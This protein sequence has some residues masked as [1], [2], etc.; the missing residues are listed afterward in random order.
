M[1]LSLFP[2]YLLHFL[3]SYFFSNISFRE[4]FFKEWHLSHLYFQEKWSPEENI[5]LKA[6]T[7]KP[8]PCSDLLC[9]SFSF[10]WVANFWNVEDFLSKPD[11]WLLLKNRKV[12]QHQSHFHTD[13]QLPAPE[14]MKVTHLEKFNHPPREGVCFYCWR[15]KGRT[16]WLVCINVALIWRLLVSRW[17][18]TCLKQGLQQRWGGNSKPTVKGYVLLLAKDLPWTFRELNKIPILKWIMHP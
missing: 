15:K 18:C 13:P 7:W 5:P 1:Y 11:L 14:S 16:Y 2:T 4:E 12:W 10:E 3:H 6:I 8:M 17:F 9:N